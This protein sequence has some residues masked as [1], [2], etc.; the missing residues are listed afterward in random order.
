MTGQN[1]AYFISW[2]P[3]ESKQAYDDETETVE[4]DIYFASLQIDGQ[5]VTI[6]QW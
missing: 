6:R 2:T 3:R 5:P 1:Q 4:Y